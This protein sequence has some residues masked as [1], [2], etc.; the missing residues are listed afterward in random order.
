M[1]LDNPSISVKELLNPLKNQ[2]I[3]ALIFGLLLNRI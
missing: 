2:G 1:Y 3:I